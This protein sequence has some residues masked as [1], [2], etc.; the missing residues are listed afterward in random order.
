MYIYIKGEILY[1]DI[2]LFA[3]IAAVLATNLYRFRKKKVSEKKH[4]RIKC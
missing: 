2:I 4:L 3:V 1:I